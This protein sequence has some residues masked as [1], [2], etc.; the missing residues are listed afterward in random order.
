MSIP[1]QE[2]TMELRE[3]HYS[4]GTYTIKH[5][6]YGLVRVSRPTGTDRKLFGSDLKHG[7]TVSIE[8]SY[9]EEDRM[10]NKSWIHERGKI[11]EIEM[12]EAQWAHF[13]SSA[14][15]AP[16]PVT[17]RTVPEGDLKRLPWIKEQQT[18]KQK[19]SKEYQDKVDMTVEKAENVLKK[20]EELLGKGKA[21]KKEL[22]ELK[23]LV[24]QSIGR[25][26]S[27]TVFSV[28]MFE[29]A[30]E[31]LVEGAKIQ[32]ESH[33][34]L[35]AQKIGAEHMGISFDGSMLEDKR[36]DNE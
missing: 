26:K 20:L 9:A 36:G 30:M 31:D 3:G 21:S 16:T 35:T 19:A 1:D 8:F 13:V 6:A 24:Q 12:S 33:I 23:G 27:D 25:F 7:S 32:I 14:G 29:E 17:L 5:P 22:T 34:M 15:M 11:L 2:P 10:L 4:A 18:E 28:D